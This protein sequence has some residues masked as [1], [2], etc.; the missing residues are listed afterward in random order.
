MIYI[1][2]YL[3]DDIYIYVYI[4]IYFPNF[5]S[6]GGQPTKHET[7]AFESL[8]SREVSRV[9][10]RLPWFMALVPWRQ[11]RCFFLCFLRKIK[12]LE[13]KVYNCIAI[14]VPELVSDF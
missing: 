9:G 11:L 12:S 1:Y 8:H 6:K 10:A 3:T 7:A 13:G 4:Y 14:S 5:Q 2:I